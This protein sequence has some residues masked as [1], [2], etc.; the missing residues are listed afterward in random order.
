MAVV[1]SFDDDFADEARIR[2]KLFLN[3]DFHMLN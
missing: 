3:Q 2:M 1:I